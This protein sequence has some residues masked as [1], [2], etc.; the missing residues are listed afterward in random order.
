MNELQ[1][2]DPVIYTDPASHAEKHGVVV[3]VTER[4]VWVRIRGNNGV[5]AVNPKNLKLDE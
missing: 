5:K 4:F 3:N 2:A 1:I